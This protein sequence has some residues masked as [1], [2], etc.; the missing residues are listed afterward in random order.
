MP[1]LFN[2]PREFRHGAVAMKHSTRRQGRRDDSRNDKTLEKN[3]ARERT[4]DDISSQV[5]REPERQSR[6]ELQWPRSR[7]W[8]AHKMLL[9]DF[10][11]G[12][13]SGCGK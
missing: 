2:L 12:G 8:Y 13:N 3:S 4:S 6:R 5:G 7:D 11:C 9:I 10:V 1:V